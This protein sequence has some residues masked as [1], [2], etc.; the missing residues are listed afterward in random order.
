MVYVFSRPRNQQRLF[1]F[2]SLLLI[3]VGLLVGFYEHD[4]YQSRQQLW[5]VEA[6][7]TSLRKFRAPFHEN[8]DRVPTLTPRQFYGY[9]VNSRP[10]I[11]TGS[12]CTLH[13]WTLATIER[14][15]GDDYIGV[16]TTT[17]N[18]RFSPDTARTVNMTV[19]DFL[20]RF[21]A[22]GRDREY[23]LAEGPLRQMPSLY[24]DIREPDF[25]SSLEPQRDPQLWIGAGGQVSTMHFD[26]MENVLC[27]IEGTR[28][29]F[30][31]DP[32][33]VGRLYPR[34]GPLRA[35]SQV[36]PADPH[37]SEKFPKF[38]SAK[39]RNVTLRAGESLFIPSMWYHQIH[40]G[41]SMNIAV[42]F[43]YTS[44]LLSRLAM[45]NM[46]PP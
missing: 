26:D 4:S 40:G 34:A 22:P 14:M 28:V 31:F 16:E 24:D 5:L 36:D 17:G 25:S 21:M 44:H 18:N 41:P 12:S 42:N 35:H 38:A 1:R 3:V 20:A 39:Q 6:M 43:W 33:Q 30:L 8:V 23:Y 13:P 15:A 45:D 27:Q 46:I 11:V 2:I 19:R 9:V 37:A 29:V 32:L 10:V 7:R